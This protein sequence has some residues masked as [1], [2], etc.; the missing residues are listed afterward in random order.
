MLRTGPYGDAFGAQPDG[1]TLAALE[2]QPHGID[3]GPLAPRIPE[4][5][6]TPS[7]KIELAPPEITAD[8][9]RLRSRL[10]RPEGELTL[11]GRRDLRSNNSWMHN[12][13]TLV[14]GK[15]RCT[16]WVHPDDAARLGLADGGAARV[17]SR[18]GRLEVPVEVTDAIMPGVVSVPHGWGHD[19]PGM[20]LRVASAHAGVNSNLLADELAMDPLSG[21]A[22]LNG[23]PVTVEPAA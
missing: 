6:R 4:V 19:A 9:P 17:R 3:F 20:A 21:N 8:V 22:V 13:E 12:I 11:V 7:G 1:L 5:L 23:I 18:A 14:R 10:S 2:A 16:L 15:P